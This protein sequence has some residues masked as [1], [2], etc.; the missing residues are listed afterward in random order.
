MDYYSILGVDKNA[1]P[2]DIKKAYRKLAAQHHPDRGGNEAKFK[3]VQEAYDT[4]GDP[5]KRQQYDNPQP[6]FQFNTGNMGGFGDIFS[7]FGFR[8]QGHRNPNKDVTIAAEIELEDV[9]F[10]KNLI[11]A[12]RLQNGREER[13]DIQIP[14]GIQDGQQIRYQGLGEEIFR[15]FPRGNLNVI[16]RVRPHPIWQAHNGNLITETKVSAFEAMLGTNKVI[17]T[18][19]RKKVSLK[20]PAGTQPDTTFSISGHGLITRTGQRGN[21]HVVVKIEIPKLSKEEQNIV[22]NLY[23]KSNQNS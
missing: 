10:G 22:E 11:A 7:N 1:S 17:E 4:L 2:Q 19:D 18:I 23:N 5:S 6:H 15:E 16:I 20:I 3:Q 8:S 21:A 12:Y 9:L 13:V 14:P